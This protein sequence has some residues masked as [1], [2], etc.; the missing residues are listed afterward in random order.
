MVHG[1]LFVQE[2]A[3]PFLK[4]SEGT[5]VVKK[6]SRQQCSSYPSLDGNKQT[7]Q[8]SFPGQHCAGTS[9]PDVHSHCQATP[10]EEQENIYS[11]TNSMENATIHT[12]SN[13]HQQQHQHQPQPDDNYQQL[14]S[15]Q[16]E[17]P[18]NGIP[19]IKLK[20]T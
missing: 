2:S 20:Y 16:N 18:Q 1:L 5:S 9:N 3:H 10:D 13:Y 4:K 14:Q 6:G 11:I 12:N 19:V 7:K 17:P 8:I 15:N